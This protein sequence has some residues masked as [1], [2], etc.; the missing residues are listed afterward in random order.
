MAVDQIVVSVSLQIKE[1]QL[2]Q[3]ACPP[4]LQCRKRLL[5]DGNLAHKFLTLSLE[6]LAGQ[7]DR[8]IVLGRRE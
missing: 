6:F 3:N 5:D 8:T 7:I 2:L 1:Q 4:K